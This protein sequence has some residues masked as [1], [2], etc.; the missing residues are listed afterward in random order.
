[1][2]PKKNWKKN[3]FGKN[4]KMFFSTHLVDALCIK[5]KSPPLL[6]WLG[7]LVTLFMSKTVEMTI[8]GRFFTVLLKKIFKNFFF[9]KTIF[10]RHRVE[11]SDQMR[12]L[13]L[14]KCS[15][16]DWYIEH[17]T[18]ILSN[19]GTP[20]VPVSNFYSCLGLGGGWLLC[21]C[22]RKWWTWLL[23]VYMVV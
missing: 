18:Y 10:T 9:Q 14:F 20:T 4:K 5:I 12:S 11:Y 16:S 22:K 21:C 19:I 8:F 1:V 15:H 7:G 3:F 13:Y 6:V 2:L 17:I 23:P